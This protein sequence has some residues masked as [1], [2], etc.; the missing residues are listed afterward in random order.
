[1]LDELERLQAEGGEA[2]LK[3]GHHHGR[4]SFALVHFPTAGGKADI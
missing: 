3:A 2:A 4:W 1:M